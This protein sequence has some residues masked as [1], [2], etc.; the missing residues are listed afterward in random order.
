MTILKLEGQT[1]EFGLVQF[2]HTSSASVATTAGARSR[3][4]CPTAGA[5]RLPL[6]PRPGGFVLVLAT[7]IGPR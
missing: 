5:L 3:S 2:Y 1:A 7:A 6:R 4:G